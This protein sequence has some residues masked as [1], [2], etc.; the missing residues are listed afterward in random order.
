V[1][2]SDAAA[3]A[4]PG[5]GDAGAGPRDGWRRDGFRDGL[6]HAGDA[7]GDDERGELAR[8]R[9]ALCVAIHD[10]AP[11]TWPSC[12]RLLQAVRAV[13]DIPLTWL[14][15]PRFHDNPARSAACESTLDTLLAEGH[16]L[17]LHGYTHLDPAPQDGPLP[18]YLV[19]NVY[20]QREGEFSAIGTDEARRRIELGLGWFR[21]RGWCPAGFVAP[22]WL[23][24]EAAWQA[25]REYPFAYTTSYSRFY[26]LPGR[27]SVLAPA[28][29]YAA[30]NRA[31]RLLSPPA[32]SLMAT[33]LRGAPLVRLAL[34]PRDAA[35]PALLRHAQRLLAHLLEAREPLTKSAF[36]ARAGGRLTSTVPSIHPSPT[37]AVRSRRN[38]T[39]QSGHS[40][41]WR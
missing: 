4:Q 36:A 19:R 31:G 14:V 6:P 41:P 11:A 30:R 13:A 5:G 22:A 38:T 40:H 23:L 18:S 35:H 32:V 9:P 33:L 39:D 29:V 2:P 12:V 10:V 27:R 7:S 37:D 24:G 20:T 34:H 16:E 15:V 28:L 17:A 8:A 3:G 1:S 26:L 25:L 21:Q